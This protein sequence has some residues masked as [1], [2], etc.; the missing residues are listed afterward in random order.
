MFA[1]KKGGGGG[2]GGGRAE[3]RG[4]KEVENKAR[5]IFHMNFDTHAKPVDPV[6]GCS[7]T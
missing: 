7:R 5:R 6:A 2:G 4:E 1:P 3:G